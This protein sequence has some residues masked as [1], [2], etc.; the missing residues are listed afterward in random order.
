MRRDTEARRANSVDCPHVGIRNE[1]VVRRLC[2][3]AVAV[4]DTQVR[5]LPDDLQ[6]L[7]VLKNAAETGGA[8]ALEQ[9]AAANASVRRVLPMPASPRTSAARPR[10]ERAS[11]RSASNCSNS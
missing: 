10:P 9:L 5:E 3:R 2:Q 8:N 6:P 7:G 11:S 4:A 1:R